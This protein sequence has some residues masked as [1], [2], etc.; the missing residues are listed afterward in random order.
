M[1]TIK[2][3][4]AVLIVLACGTVGYMIA[5]SYKREEKTLRKLIYALDYMECE[6][7][8]RMPALPDLCR[9]T[10]NETD[11]VVSK[12]FAMLSNELEDQIS[13]DVRSC[14]KAVTAKCRDIPTHTLASFL[15]L[16]DSMGRFDLEGQLKGLESVRQEA[17]MKLNKLMGNSDVRLRSYQTLGICAGAAIVIILM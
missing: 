13:P 1:M 14:M 12:V 10:A 15:L 4:G 17:R 2:L 8:F 9:N 7:Q 5:A 16:G 11:G 3:I 6:L